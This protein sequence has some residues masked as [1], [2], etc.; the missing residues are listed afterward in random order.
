[1]VEVIQLDLA[2]IIILPRE[3]RGLIVGK[4]AGWTN[5]FTLHGLASADVDDRHVGRMQSLQQQIK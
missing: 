3:T 1:L 2:S 4:N 5:A